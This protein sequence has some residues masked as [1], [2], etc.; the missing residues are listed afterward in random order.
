MPMLKSLPENI[1]DRL[2]SVKN[3]IKEF[4]MGYTVAGRSKFHIMLIRS[5]TLIL[6]FLFLNDLG[7]LKA[8]VLIPSDKGK[9]NTVRLNGVWKFKYIPSLSLQGDSQFYRTDVNLNSWSD[10][11][12]PGNWEL[13]GFAEPRYGSNVA[14]A[15]GLY[16]TSFFVPSGWK[17]QL[18]FVAFDGVQYGYDL[19]VNGTFAG[20]FASAYNRQT[21]DI[22]KLVEYGKN[23]ILA[24]KVTTRSK[25]WDFDTNDDWALSGIIRDVT[26][27]CLPQTH[28]KDVV[29]KT[30]VEKDKSASV[31]L[32]AIIGRTNLISQSKKLRVN[33]RL[34]D[35]DGK[36]IKE[37]IVTG[38]FLHEKDILSLEGIM[39][40]EKPFLWTA[41]TP[42]LYNLSVVLSENGKDLQT[43]NLKIGIRQVSIADGILLINGVPVKLRGVDHHDLSPLNGKAVSEAEIK[44]DLILIKKANINFIRTSHY[45]PHSRLIELCDSMGIYVM[46]EVALGYGDRNFQDPLILPVLY[47]RARATVWRDKNNPSVIAWS[48]G[49]ENK[50]TESG[51]KTGQYVK[52]LDNTRPYCFPTTGS[53]FSTIQNEYPDSVDI[54]A[55]HYPTA[56]VL[57]ELS[58]MFDRPL[59]ITEYAHSL[60]LDF[61]RTEVLWEI[62]Y[63]S[64][65]IA[66][67]ALWHFFDQGI[68]RK[69]PVKVDVNSFTKGVWIDSLMYYD[70]FDNKGADG[71][72]YAN[73]VPQPDYWQV[74]K[75]YSPVKALDDL[76]FIKP[77]R[78]TIS[79]RHNNRFDFNDLSVI[80]CTW[81]LFAD[82]TSVQKGKL[83]LKCQPRDTVVSAINITLPD[84]LSAFYYLLK[85][86]YFDS[87]SYQFYE[88]T[89][90]L[91]PEASSIQVKNLLLARASRPVLKNK[92]TI[93]FNGGE[94]STDLA[95]G[96]IRLSNV[97][98]RQLISDGPYARVGRK[99]TMGSMVEAENV[100]P[101]SINKGYNMSW[102][103]HILKLP[104]V[105]SRNISE[106]NIRTHFNYE[107]VL[108]NGQFING[109]VNFSVS[110]SGYIDVDYNFRP[111][112]ANGIFLEAGISFL[113]P[114]EY[115]EFRWT[116]M[117]PYPSYPGK[118]RLNEFGIYHLN[119]SDINYQ[120]NFSGIQIAVISDRNGNGF[121]LLCHNANIALEK[122]PDGIIFSH[123]ALLSGRYNKKVLPETTIFAKDVR[124]ITGHFTLVPLEKEWPSVLQDLFGRP[125]AVAEPFKPF[126][127]SYDQ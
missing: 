61:D 109:E 66:G 116:G 90:R 6:F 42:Y 24:V 30:F 119:S 50:I 33:G 28:I 54:L 34:T 99:P 101:D 120:G 47:T 70:N 19:W 91:Y 53:Y 114:P 45:P 16:R 89:Y 80:S 115:T 65:K 37:I 95:A 56:A 67:G 10:I 7:P 85:L 36:L 104:E 63:K 43:Q 5:L 87:G 20:S 39:K 93:D 107:R 110:D 31:S 122:T 92:N 100:S 81:E 111:V 40:I 35:T 26:L 13:Q 125:D 27:F 51:L 105:I 112:N 98:G 108:S 84:K 1:N 32:S 22:S 121:A 9:D 72:V 126:Y 44:K 60:G 97:S 103:P 29:V 12:V 59:I 71:L 64:P 76:I 38:N 58:T 113:I 117:G 96:M 49:N 62:M 2:T 94:L 102:V 123:N 41:E 77:G 11:K 74:R 118:E 78:Q 127:H 48:V 14:E 15:T 52:K 18:V 68:L 4:R 73:R 57:T 17:S 79:I 82:T 75:V 21:F 3:L 106:N 25:G 124:Q 8:Q 23:N 55:P 69:S 88:K 46:D 83:L 86:K